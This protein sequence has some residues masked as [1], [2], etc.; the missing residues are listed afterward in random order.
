[1]SIIISKKGQPAQ[2][3]DRSDF[4][5]EDYLQNYIHENPESI[6]VYEIQEDKRL[7]VMAREFE[8]ESGPIDA[9]AVDKDGDIYVVET[10]LYKN[11]DKRTVVA[12]ALD[13]G[14]SMWKHTNDFEEFVSVLDKDVQN[15]FGMSLEDKIKD[16]FAIDTEQ[17][18]FLMDAMRMN[19][20]EGKIKFV[21][22]MDSMDERLKDLI[23][24]VNQ[25][26]Q[27]DIFAVQLEYYKFQEYEIMIPK[28]FG[29]EVKKN[30][31]SYSGQR[32]TWSREDSLMDAKN[33]DDGKSYKTILSMLEFSEK[34]ADKVIYGTGNSGVFSFKLKNSQGEGTLFSV[35]SNGE[36]WSTPS[37]R[38]HEKFSEEAINKLSENFKKIEKVKIEDYVEKG[39][40]YEDFNFSELDE[41]GIK[42]LKEVL[43]NFIDEANL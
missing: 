35:Y 37:L 42:K 11:P 23:I 28:M 34:Y 36:I 19:L 8:T 26:S 9:L 15:K 1:M 29:V 4:E 39:K 21:I 31:K 22:L 13:Y 16:F 5:K 32:K 10:K 7:F 38:L 20:R 40:K 25:N 43:K 14:A 12:Q 2:K 27:F 30:I 6:P 3:L 18:K 24:Y 17:I 33:K 41:D